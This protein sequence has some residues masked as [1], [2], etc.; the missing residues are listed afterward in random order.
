[1]ETLKGVAGIYWNALKLKI[2]GAPFH[3]HPDK[4]ERDDRAYQRGIRDT[5][6]DVTRRPPEKHDNELEG[7]VSSWRT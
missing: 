3:T 2:K 4:L 7:R 1:M 5:G 6:L